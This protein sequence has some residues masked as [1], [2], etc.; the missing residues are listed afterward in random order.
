MPSHHVCIWNAGRTTNK[1]SGTN[2]GKASFL[3][4]EDRAIDAAQGGDLATLTAFLHRGGDVE[5]RDSRLGMVRLRFLFAW[6]GYVSLCSVLLYHVVLCC[7]ILW[8]SVLFCF[9][10]FRRHVSKIVGDV[11]RA[12]VNMVDIDHNFAKTRQRLLFSLS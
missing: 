3:S 2:N 11:L 9:E 4:D 6:C 1:S 5:L 12:I 10:C 7:V 8:S